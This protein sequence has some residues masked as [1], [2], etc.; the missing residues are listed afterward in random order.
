MAE[1]K[2]VIEIVNKTNGGAG[3]KVGGAGGIKNKTGGSSAQSGASG[4]FEDSIEKRLTKMLAPAALVRGGKSIID[5]IVQH[6][7]GLIEIRTGSKEQQQRVSFIY[8]TASGFV[9]SALSGAGMGF[10]M[11]GGIGAGVGA[12]LGVAKQSISMGINYLKQAD[13][14]EK[15]RTL[16]QMQQ[17]LA[18]QRVTI[19]GSRYMNVTQY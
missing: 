17:N 8:N 12:L 5:Q 6:N 19:S 18:S 2:F 7:N 4:S 16:E 11:G 10:M 15:Q 14:L 3:N 9:D 13:I 1:E